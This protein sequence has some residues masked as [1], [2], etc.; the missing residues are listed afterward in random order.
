MEW[1]SFFYMLGI[2]LA[3][4]LVYRQ[5]RGN[6]LAFTKESFLKSGVTLGVLTLILIGF[7]TLLILMLR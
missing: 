4:W 1:S 5:V 3:G 6:P 2:L 7:I